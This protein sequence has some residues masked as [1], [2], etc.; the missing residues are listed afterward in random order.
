MASTGC[1][2]VWIE[3]CF[4]D[5]ISPDAFGRLNAP[6]VRE[7]VGEIRAAGLKSVY[8]YCGDPSTRLD[9]LLEVGADALHLEEGKKGFRIEID[10]IAEAVGG[11][12]VLFGNLDSIAVLQDGSEERL[13]GEIRRQIQ[14]GRAN[15]GRFVVSTG[16]PVTPGTPLGRVRLYT[17]TAHRLGRM[18]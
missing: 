8:Y 10:E 5:Q 14:A 6:L 18:E 2:F 7:L 12:C 1:H 15:G 9:Q 16:S 3:E 13:G 11:R 4:T 17:E